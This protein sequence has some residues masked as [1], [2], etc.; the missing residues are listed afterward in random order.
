[1][2]TKEILSIQYLR[3]VAALSVLAFH[4]IVR[5][6]G[7]LPI[8]ASGVDIFFVISGF[9]MWVTTADRRVTPAGFMLK[10][11]VRIV[12]NYWIATVVTALLIL[13]R[14][15]FMHG[16]ELDPCRFFGSLF[17]LPTLAGNKLLPVVLQGWTLIYE[18]IFYI[19]FAA[20]LFVEQRRRPY[21]ITA[22]LCA[23]AIL[24]ATATEPHIVSVTNPMLLEFLAGVWVGI[25]WKN[26]DIPPGVAAMLF[27]AG[28]ICLVLSECLQPDLPQVVKFGVPAVFLVA[29][30][31]FY[32]KTTDVRE[33]RMLRFL[34]AA[35]YSIYIWHVVLA[36]ILEGLLLRI[37]LPLTIH[38]LLEATGTVFFTCIIYIAVELPITRYLQMIVVTR[39]LQPARERIP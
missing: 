32:E 29:G 14:P 1:V 37:H 26:S 5:F 12:P 4:L 25:L 9:V 33:I 19:L 38:A 2:P 31:A 36:T 13:V 35:S 17:F 20:S 7:P 8:G 39:P 34:G 6:D 27:V 23:L 10:R 24:H 30:S 21:L 3:A 22:T 28:A 16:H 18:M 11:I 15:N